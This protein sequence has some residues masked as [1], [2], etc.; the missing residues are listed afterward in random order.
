MTN[1]YGPTALHACKLCTSTAVY[2]EEA[3]PEA[4]AHF[5]PTSLSSQKKGCPKNAFLGLAAAGRIKGVRSKGNASLNGQYACLAHDLLLQDR[6]WADQPPLSLW[7]Y[8]MAQ[9]G[10]PDKQPNS[11]MHV[12]LALWHAGLLE[13]T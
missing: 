9:R 5:M 8:I 11:Q 4:A 6:A 7:R 10:T 3:W 13:G 1:H 2:A 12:V